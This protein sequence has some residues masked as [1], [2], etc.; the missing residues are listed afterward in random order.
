[1]PSPSERSPSTPISHGELPDLFATPGGRILRPAEWP[2]Q[3]EMWRRAVVN[4][5]HGGMPSEP[6]RVAVV[7]RS[8][9]RARRFAGAPRALTCD[10]VAWLSG[11]GSTGGEA[12]RGEATRGEATAGEATGTGTLGASNAAGD[13]AEPFRIPFRLLIPP[14]DA[15]APVIVTGDAAWWQPCDEAAARLLAAGVAIAAFDRTVVAPDMP[16]RQGGLFDLPNARFGAIAAW[17]WGYR[18]VTRALAECPEIDAARIGV[19]GFSRGGK[20]A[21]LAAATDPRIAW[22]HA[23]ASGAGGAAPYRY[24]GAGAETI[25]IAAAFPTWF[26]PD[27]R[28][29]A[30]RERDLPFD[31]HALLALIAP[32][33][34]L[35]SCGVDDAWA[36]P[37][38]TI[39]AAWAAREVYRFL[40]AP[41]AIAVTIRPGGHTLDPGDWTTGPPWQGVDGAALRIAH[42]F[43]GLTPAF[44]WRAPEGGRY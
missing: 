23:H 1:V 42:P 9:G 17:A 39:Q 41:E 27:L 31:A 25:G 19:S 37:E 10:A 2:A 32:R 3:A 5:G 34:L 15:P 21:L 11:A 29:F 43:A 16:L 24:L 7:H 26:G 44:G 6:E 14:G 20:A 38:G 30:G 28:A 33:P 35:L 18:M 12:T 4:V 13:L 40:G 22:V 8:D 36:N